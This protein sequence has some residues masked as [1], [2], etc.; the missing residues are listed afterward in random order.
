M[1]FKRN[2][3]NKGDGLDLLKSLSGGEAAVVILD[4][5]YR[6]VLDKL[7]YGN[8]GARQKARALMPQMSE[9][10][11]SAFL[12][13]TARVLRPRGHLLFW[14]DKFILVER[15]WE[16]WLGPNPALKAVDLITWEKPRIGMGYRTRRKSEYLLILQKPPIRAKGI[17]T[18]HGIPDVWSE[19]PP[20]AEGHPKPIELQRRLIC[21]VT[22]PGDLVVDPCAGSYTVMQAA[23]ACGRGFLGCDLRG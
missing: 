21:S 23:K 22:N 17:W 3:P 15:R 6:A 4:P 8:E 14:M 1:I 5:Q 18:D 20:K 19:A 13:E 12:I 11:T 2:R 9:E 10:L 7:K 16:A